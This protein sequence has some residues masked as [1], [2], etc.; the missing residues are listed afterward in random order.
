MIAITRVAGKPH[1]TPRLDAMWH[2]GIAGT[3]SG[4]FDFFE[5]FKAEISSNN[6]IRIRSGIGMLQGR[7]FAVEPSTYDEVNIGNGTQGE[8]RIDLIVARW[9]VDDENNTQNGDW[10]VIQGTPT[11]GTPAVPAH[12]TG[13]LDAGD[14]IADMPMFQVELNGVNITAIKKVYKTWALPIAQGGTGKT[15]AAEALK[16]LGGTS[17]TK[18]WENASPTSAFTAQTLTINT[19]SNYDWYVI[20]YKFYTTI[21]YAL[22]EFSAVGNGTI[23]NMADAGSVYRRNVEYSTNNLMISGVNGTRISGAAD[24]SDNKYLIPLMIYGVKGVI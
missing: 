23:I 7:F 19:L 22:M 5:S 4:V 3:E 8:K 20:I 2:R 17:L 15:T 14:L 16:N 11:T 13:D 12:T 9:T 21:N 18:I 24:I 1:I 6:K 10:Y